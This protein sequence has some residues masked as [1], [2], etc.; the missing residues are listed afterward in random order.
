MCTGID[1]SSRIFAM[2]REA[3][4]SENAVGF[5]SVKFRTGRRNLMLRPRGNGIIATVMRHEV[6]IHGDAEY[7]AN[8]PDMDL[9][10]RELGHLIH[11]VKQRVSSSE[12]AFSPL[13]APA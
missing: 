7:F 10:L 9:S 11:F 12:L 8:L 5:G 3:M 6:E 4:R 13:V 1:A 2:I